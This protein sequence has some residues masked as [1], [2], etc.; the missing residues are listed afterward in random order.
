[1]FKIRKTALE[2]GRELA[3]KHPEEFRT[4]YIEDFIKNTPWTEVDRYIGLFR[5]HEIDFEP[6]TTRIQIEE[7][8]HNPLYSLEKGDR[9]IAK[10]GDR[11]DI[12]EPEIPGLIGGEKRKK[13]YRDAVAKGVLVEALMEKKGILDGGKVFLNAKELQEQGVMVYGIDDPLYAA[14]TVECS[15]ATALVWESVQIDQDY[16][17]K[18]GYY[19]PDGVVARTG[20][21]LNGEHEKHPIFS[22]SLLNHLD[23]MKKIS[24]PFEELETQVEKKRN[25][26][27]LSLITNGKNKSLEV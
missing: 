1:M 15:K 5:S 21:Y 25:S 8:T 17:R 4:V 12:S 11:D 23:E 14:V 2:R 18:E 9:H 26:S 16:I 10:A 19:E 22:K 13:A 24:T 27:L 3:E 6:I 20:Y 7:L